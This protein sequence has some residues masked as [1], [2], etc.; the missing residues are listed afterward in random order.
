MKRPSLTS[1]ISGVGNFAGQLA[2]AAE[3]RAW[4]ERHRPE[5]VAFLERGAATEAANILNDFCKQF[6]P[7]AALVIS[8]MGGTP[9]QAI[10]SISVFDQTLGIELARCRENFARAQIAWRQLQSQPAVNQ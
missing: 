6:P 4:L 10:A 7:L 9:D 5:L 8:A 2:V 3:A 1:V